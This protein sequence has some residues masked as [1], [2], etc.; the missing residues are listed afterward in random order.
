MKTEILLAAQRAATEKKASQITMLDVTGKSDI[1]NYQMICSAANEKQTV[2]IADAIE[3]LCKAEL[4]ISP[5]ATE[6]KATGTWILLD[7]GS[8]ILHVF[9]YQ[10]REF[11]SLESLWGHA[12]RITD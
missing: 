8:V 9:Y 4:R 3:A 10:T 6:G 7:Y 1:C 12:K 2:A 11:Y 5:A